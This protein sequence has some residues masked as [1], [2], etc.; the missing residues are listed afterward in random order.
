MPAQERPRTRSY[1][2]KSP[3]KSTDPL[4]SGITPPESELSPGLDRDRVQA[5][6]RTSKYWEQMHP[7]APGK[8][9]EDGIVLDP[10]E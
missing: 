9:Y 8:T 6:L 7:D 3:T 5:V 1:T 4:A 10:E 2:A